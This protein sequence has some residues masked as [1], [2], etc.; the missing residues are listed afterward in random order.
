MS[1]NFTTDRVAFSKIQIKRETSRAAKY[2]KEIGERFPGKILA[3]SKLTLSGEAIC[4]MAK[5]WN[6][7][8]AFSATANRGVNL[9]MKT[10]IQHMLEVFFF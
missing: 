5:C 2:S 6:S 7:T 1:Y 3:S 9:E 8:Q 10:S 4:K